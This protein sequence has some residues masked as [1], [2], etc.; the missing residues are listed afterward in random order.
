MEATHRFSLSDFHI[1]PFQSNQ[2]MSPILFIFRSLNSYTYYLTLVK[3]LYR[4]N[5]SVPSK[6]FLMFFNTFFLDAYQGDWWLIHHQYTNGWANNFANASL[7]LPPP[8]SITYILIYFFFLSL[9]K[10][11]SE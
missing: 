2:S 10:D 7:F 11:P 9:K 6:F 8:E 5:K 1:T 4:E 3:N